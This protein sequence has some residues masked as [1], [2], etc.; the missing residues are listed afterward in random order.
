MA[1]GKSVK[2]QTRKGKSRSAAEHV[3]ATRNGSGGTAPAREAELA[4]AALKLSEAA[5][6][7]PEDVPLFL[8]IDAPGSVTAKPH[9]GV[10]KGLDEQGKTKALS[11]HDLS[12]PYT[13]AASDHCTEGPL[14]LTEV[15]AAPA[16]PRP[17]RAT[18]KKA[19]EQL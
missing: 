8:A 19:S 5:S 2:P 6:S 18:C 12:V 7:R 3:A 1:L 10:T 9:L 11:G 17:T 15:A 13:P 16:R 4:A 14:A